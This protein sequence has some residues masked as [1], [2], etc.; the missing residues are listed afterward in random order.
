MEGGVNVEEQR[1]YL[2][3]N[4][5]GEAT[6][7]PGVRGSRGSMVRTS[8]GDLSLDVFLASSIVSAGRYHP[9]PGKYMMQCF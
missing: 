8:P 1:Y 2:L 3:I 7:A 4:T 5:L 9:G 6:F